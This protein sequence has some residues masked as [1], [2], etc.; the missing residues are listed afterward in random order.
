VPTKPKKRVVPLLVEP[1]APAA[2]AEPPPA[3]AAEPPPA[4]AEDSPPSSPAGAAAAARPESPENC[5]F[6]PPRSSHKRWRGCEFSGP[7]AFVVNP[8]AE[9][10]VTVA[11]GISTRLKQQQK[12]GLQ[13]IWRNSFSDVNKFRVGG[14]AHGCILV[15]RSWLR[16]RGSR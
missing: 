15:R 14:E 8:G 5:S 6:L 13:F 9:R 11:A 16:A 10:Q 2:A 7:D 4:G 12:E 1:P 3:A